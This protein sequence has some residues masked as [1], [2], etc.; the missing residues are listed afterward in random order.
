M[1][2]DINKTLPNSGNALFLYSKVPLCLEHK[3]INLTEK[4]NCFLPTELNEDYHFKDL[5]M[6]F[7]TIYTFPLLEL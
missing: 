7:K 3:V 5:K 6:K 4:F 2:F 1:L